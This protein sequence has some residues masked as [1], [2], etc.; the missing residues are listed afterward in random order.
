MYKLDNKRIAS[1][2]VRV[3]QGYFGDDWWILFNT[4]YLPVGKFP[5]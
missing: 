4:E 1:K 5:E 2:T 3:I